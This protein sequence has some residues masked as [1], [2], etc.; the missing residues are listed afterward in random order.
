MGQGVSSQ[1]DA[2]LLPFLQ[3]EGEAE[4]QRLLEQIVILHAA[5]VIKDIIGYK[6]RFQLNRSG[7]SRSGQEAEDVYGEVIV[8]LLARLRDCK[9]S[10]AENAIRNFRSYVAVTTYHACYEHLRLKYPQRNSLKNKLRYLLTHQRG[11]ALWEGDDGELICGFAVWREQKKSFIRSDRF[12]QLRDAPQEFAGAVLRGESPQQMNPADL[13]AA[14]FDW[15]GHPLE[16]DELT[17]IVATLWGIKEHAMQLDGAEEEASAL[18]EQVV[19]RRSSV[20]EEVDQRLYLRRLWEEVGLLP[21]RQRAALLL[22]LRDEQGSG[23]TALLPLIGI[24]SIRQIAETLA[25]PAEELARLWPELP[26]E[27]AAIAGLLGLTRQQV[28]NLRKSA[29][30]RLARR[31]RALDQG[32]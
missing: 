5:P 10:P 20:A 6:L 28:I 25:M 30:E 3:A 16:L 19:D 14:L 31:M 8:Q 9:S 27:D 15:V 24:A 23:V 4:A 13:L 17:G 18:C 26:L 1:I 7:H 32:K 2:L 11:L 12:Q 22:N 29:R 21:V